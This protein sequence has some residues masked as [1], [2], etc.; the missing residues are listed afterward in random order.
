[1]HEMNES[2]HPSLV[3]A[4]RAKVLDMANDQGFLKNTRCACVETIAE[5]LGI[6]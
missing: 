3:T 2:V 6:S 4:Q 5:V 1:M